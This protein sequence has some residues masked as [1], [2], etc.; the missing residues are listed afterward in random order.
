MINKMT[1]TIPSHVAIIMDGNGRW[2]TKNKLPLIEGHR[3]GATRARECIRF[4]VQSGIEVLTLYTFSTENWKRD[5]G[6]KSDFFQLLHWYLQNQIDE[7]KE[8]GIKFKVIGDRSRLPEDIKELVD[9][10]EK[11]TAHNTRLTLQL[12]LSYSGRDEIVRAV[13]R[14]IGQAKAGE[15]DTVDEDIFA[16][17]L[18]TAEVPDPDLL[19]RTSG[20]LRISNYLLWQLAYTELVFVDVL[21]PEMTAQHFAGALSEFSKRK[22][23]YGT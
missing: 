7:L 23:R 8:E 10:A 5:Q 20:E 15:I 14:M 16:S 11:N 18:D 4:A 12:A 9:L 21:W 2:A 6:W 3:Q 22:R 19:I 17:Y 1:Q 13:N